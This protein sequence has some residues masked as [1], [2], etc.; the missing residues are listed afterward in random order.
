MME[1]LENRA[2]YGGIAFHIRKT[3][4]MGNKYDT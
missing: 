2:Y 1:D 4:S 3:K